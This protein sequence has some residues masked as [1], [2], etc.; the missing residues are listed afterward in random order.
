MYIFATMPASDQSLATGPIH[1][2]CLGPESAVG[3]EL[4][5]LAERITIHPLLI[6]HRHQ[7]YISD[8]FMSSSDID[9]VSG[10]YTSRY[11]PWQLS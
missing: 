5:F 9:Q 1:I 8:Y 3:A 10:Q 11:W 7:L 6:V 4:F 2:I